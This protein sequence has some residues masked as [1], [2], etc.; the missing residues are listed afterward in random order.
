MFAREKETVVT[1][2]HNNITLFV[3]WSYSVA[4]FLLK[5]APLTFFL[6]KIIACVKFFVRKVKLESTSARNGLLTDL[7]GKMRMEKVEGSLQRVSKLSLRPVSVHFQTVTRQ[8]NSSC[9]NDLAI[10]YFL[11][12]LQTLIIWNR[13]RVSWI[14]RSSQQSAERF[15][16]RWR[17][18]L[19]GI[20]QP[21]AQ[22]HLKVSVVHLTH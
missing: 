19:I 9:Y 7:T 14:L 18:S 3:S 16:V 11:T 5:K 6:R 15:E 4:V 12:K 17:Y 2:R 8:F 1:F 20:G 13:G 21:I 22:N 10:R